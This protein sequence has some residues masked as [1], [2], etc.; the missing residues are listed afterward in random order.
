VQYTENG[1]EWLLSFSG[2]GEAAKL[3]DQPEQAPVT[4]ETR[5][6]QTRA[7]DG[8]ASAAGFNLGDTLLVTGTPTVIISR[9]SAMSANRK[10]AISNPGRNS[11]AAAWPTSRADFVFPQLLSRE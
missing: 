1:K 2:G 11:V 6:Q 3:I 9:P 4:E 8:G 10:R 5:E 7:Y